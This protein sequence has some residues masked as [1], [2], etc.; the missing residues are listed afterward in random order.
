MSDAVSTLDE[1]GLTMAQVREL[2]GRDRRLL[3]FLLR[4]DQFDALH[5]C[6]DVLIPQNPTHVSLRD[7]R[8]RALLAQDRPDEAL[9][10]IEERLQCRESSVAR[11]L[12]ARI[13]LA[14]GDVEVARQTAQDLVAQREESSMAWN[15]LGE[16]ELARGD[17]EAALSAYRHLHDLYPN[18]RAYLLGMVN[19]YSARGDWVTASGYAVQL[20]RLADEGNPLSVAYLRRLRYYFRAS[21]EATRVSEME[22]ELESRHADELTEL[23]EHFSPTHEPGPAPEREAPRPGPHAPS[24]PL[25]SFDDVPVCDEERRTITCAAQRFFGFDSLLPGQLQTIASV[26]R[27]EDVLTVLPTGG[28]KSLCYQ[29]PAMLAEAPGH[30]LA[31]RRTTLVIS[32]LIALMKDQIDSLPRTVRR[33]ATT[34]NSTLD[35]DELHR[36]MDRVA[37]GVYRLVYAAPERLRQP[38]FLHALRRA[39]VE[40][41]VV[42]EAHC[43]SMWGHDFRPDYLIIGQTRQAL[44]GPP[45]LA[46]TAT[47]PTRVR[48]DILERLQSA[49]SSAYSPRIVA[50]DVTR[51][52]LRL[53][54]F[55]ARDNDDKLRYL[56]SFCQAEMGSGIVYADTRAR[57]ERLAALLRRHGVNAAHYHAGIA[58]R[59][60]AQD[61]F[62]SGRT[63][64]VVATIAFA[65]GIDKSDI[66]F[67]LHFFPPASLEAYYQEAGRAGRDGLPAR[68]VLMVS[69]Y[70]K[71]LLTRRMRRDV[72]RV[73]FL[74]EVY[75]AVKHRLDGKPAGRVVMAD[76]ERDLRADDTRVR[77]ALSLLEE[78]GLLRRG[79]DL[80]R[81]ALIHLSAVC[82]DEALPEDLAAFRRAARLRPQQ[83]L[84][85]DLAEVAPRANIPLAEIEGKVLTWEDAGWLMYRPAGRDLLV[86]LLP[87]P[88]GAAECVDAL[89]ERYETVQLQRVDEIAA[90]A[91]TRHCRHGH[92]NAYLG[93]RAIERCDACDN[94][95]AV[96]PPPDPGLPDEREQLLT[97]LRCV[98]NAPWSWG[99][100]TLMRILRG[101]DQARHH[102]RA[103]HEKACAQAEFGALAFRSKT[104]IGRMM[105]RL[106][107]AGFLAPRQLEHGGVVLD[108]TTAGRAA[109][110]DP[111]RLDVLVVTR[112]RRGSDQAAG[113]TSRD[114]GED[115]QVDEALFETLRAWRLEQAREQ[116]VAAFVVFHDSHLRA[117]AAR[118]P[119]SLE[120][121]SEVG[122]VGPRRLERYGAALIELIG[123]HL[124]S[125]AKDQE[126]LSIPA[127]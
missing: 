90:Y 73:E 98:A 96:P 6:L 67:I 93:G 79:P 22:A 116:E 123:Q 107:Y 7:L 84:T 10:V 32:P 8:A 109:L 122:G 121:L 41:L 52:N 85:L 49:G 24:E 72:M 21:G 103:L 36:R 113:R 4:W 46:M 77:V 89:L 102:R 44:G 23:R 42:D 70:D 5:A 31:D 40:R 74:R 48:R 1:L 43:V 82:R 111:S 66:R 45:L 15:L 30:E 115:L 80:P 11:A 105:E 64:V 118:C 55:K 119:T 28:G 106:E 33:R 38:P 114:R 120:A 18:S 71:G 2:K 50:G 127:L 57:C 110:Q 35:S 81:A 62:M 14:R 29:L 13:C 69:V 16:V 51:P 3:N 19:I 117:I 88:E 37:D 126:G 97:I 20:L 86:E 60:R 9:P 56:L 27:G 39:G 63:R 91:D 47:A 78:A 99:R 95:L 25:P 83:W 101:D 17:E 76:L 34:I 87:S 53:E 12:L 92:I 104:A 59:H 65:L 68:C 112:K 26:L 61:D 94:C 58:D 100:Q 54:V 124:Q 108:L 125:G 75:A